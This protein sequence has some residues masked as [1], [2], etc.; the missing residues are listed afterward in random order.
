MVSRFI[1]YFKRSFGYM[2]RYSN[3]QTVLGLVLAE[4]H[5]S[6]YMFVH[7]FKFTY[8][9]SKPLSVLEMSDIVVLRLGSM[10]GGVAVFVMNLLYLVCLPFYLFYLVFRRYL[11]NN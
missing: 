2:R 5:H 7:F 3:E 10:C 1:A 9:P 8:E 6:L 4:V 11:L